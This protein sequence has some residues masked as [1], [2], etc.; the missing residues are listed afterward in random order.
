MYSIKINIQKE[1]SYQFNMYGSTKNCHTQNLVKS[2]LVAFAM[3]NEQSRTLST[4]AS[5]HAHSSCS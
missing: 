1:L 4:P 2:F 5:K 3:L